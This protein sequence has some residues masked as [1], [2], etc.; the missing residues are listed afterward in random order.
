M[1]A[2]RSP[3]R[4]GHRGFTL[5]E[6]LIVIAIIALLVGLLLPALS[7]ARI[8][9]RKATCGSNLH[10]FGLAY[11]NYATDFKD[12]IA[13]MTWYHGR[14]WRVRDIADD[15]DD[16]YTFTPAGSDNQG[17]AQQAVAIF[18]YR[19][20]RRD[21]TQID[22]WIPHILYSHLVLNDYLQQRLPE[23]MVA[24]PEDRN[25]LAWQ[26]AVSG[27]RDNPSQ[28]YFAITERPAGNGNA[29]NRWPYSSSYRLVPSA[30]SPDRVSPTGVL[31]VSQ[32]P[33]G[34]R[35]YVAGDGNTRL[36]KRTLS[37]VTFPNGKVAVFDGAGNHA[38]R[39]RWFYA[40][41]EVTQPMLFWDSSVVEKNTGRCNRGFDPNNPQGNG[42]TRIN[43]SPDTLWEPP[44]R[45]GAASEYVNGYEQ[46]TREG[47]RGNDFSAKEIHN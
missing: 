14:T 19:A 30:F 8:A 16:T 38:G 22:G 7:Q 20:D 31:T 11:A 42:P 32:S 47:L 26:D 39:R 43:Y 37:E 21:I 45:S 34:H 18:R 6:L 4:V 15:S 24:C 25:R 1:T 2:R 33:A 9:S 28:A 46:W 36:G 10:Q 44:T 27:N 13:S 29:D 40:Y 3:F 12:T 5:I 35:Y 41:E 17:A 23:R